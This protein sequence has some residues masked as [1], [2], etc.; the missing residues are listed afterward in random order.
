MRKISSYQKLKR[1]YENARSEFLEDMT[2]LLEQPDSVKA[3][4]VEAKWR[5]IIEGN[6]MFSL[7]R[8]NKI[9]SRGLI[10]YLE[11]RYR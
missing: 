8:S 4:E 1:K 10:D 7:G 9:E 11:K 5:T 6:K 2:T 3:I